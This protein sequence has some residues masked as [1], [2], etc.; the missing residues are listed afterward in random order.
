M[1][2]LNLLKLLITIQNRHWLLR[3]T[4][5]KLSTRSRNELKSDELVVESDNDFLFALFT[6]LLTFKLV[7]AIFK[8]IRFCRVVSFFS[9]SFS[10]SLISFS[11]MCAISIRAFSFAKAFAIA[12]DTSSSKKSRRESLI[13]NFTRRESSRVNFLNFLLS[14]WKHKHWS[15]WLN[16]K[17]KLS[18]DVCDYIQKMQQCQNQFYHKVATLSNF[19]HVISLCQHFYSIVT[20]IIEF[21]TF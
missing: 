6:F 2:L 3:M 7:N 13:L 16:C 20:M 18:R 9:L 4:T 8:A 17:R 15:K 11:L 14:C 1:N 12:R 19:N 21:S 5:F 10:F